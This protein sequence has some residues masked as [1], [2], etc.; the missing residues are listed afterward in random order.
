MLLPLYALG[1]EGLPLLDKLAS[2]LDNAMAYTVAL[3]MALELGL[4]LTKSTKPLS[5]LYGAA[6]VCHQLATLSGKLGTLLDR[7]LPQRLK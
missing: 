6:Y 5:L 3:S 4:R 2:H 1:S 7:M